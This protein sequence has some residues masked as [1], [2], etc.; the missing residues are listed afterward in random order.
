MILSIMA[1]PI[2]YSWQSLRLLDIFSIVMFLIALP[3]VSI[4]KENLVI[5]SLFFV[6]FFFSILIGTFSIVEFDS[7][8]LIF[9]YK[10][11]YPFLLVL[12]FYN[13][14]LNRFQLKTLVKYMFFTHIFLVIWVYVYIYMVSVGQIHGSFRPSFPFSNDFLASDA[15]LYSSVLAIG[16][17][18]FT[19]YFKYINSSKFLF[20]I[21]S[22]TAMM[23]TGSRTGILVYIIGMIMYLVFIKK[24][25]LFVIFA[26]SLLSLIIIY[27]DMPLIPD[28]LTRVVDR[29]TSSDF[30]NDES[31]KGRIQKL[32]IGLH[33]SEK[34]YFVFGTGVLNSSL[35]WYDSLIGS[36]MSH[37]GLLGFIVFFLMLYK[38]KK[39]TVNLASKDNEKAAIFTILLVCYVF[40]N[41]I[42]EYFLISRGVF[43]IVVYLS[44]LHQYIKIE[45]SK[46]NNYKSIILK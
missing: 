37:V 4:K 30:L 39:N 5:V 3:F 14:N 36:L 13:L 45:H 42:T 16:T 11:L 9:I 35:I 2:N 34:M 7:K 31:I 38:L 6:I 23:L 24:N 18:F 33:D 19:M 15:H 41:F 43:P 22:L 29:V 8:R 27:F 10:Y 44:I 26:F 25:F 12:V 40:A 21:L 46:N 17:L 28:E 1:F 20:L 32:G